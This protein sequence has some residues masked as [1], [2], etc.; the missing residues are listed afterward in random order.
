MPR[1][2]GV[3]GQCFLDTFFHGFDGEM[4]AD[5][6]PASGSERFE[7]D[8]GVSEYAGLWHA[9]RASQFERSCE[10]VLNE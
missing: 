7:D 6:S 2:T 4:A 3:S 9:N 10:I 5:R 8:I 1:I